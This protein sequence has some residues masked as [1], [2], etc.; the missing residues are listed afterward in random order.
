MFLVAFASTAYF[1]S[2]NEFC[3]F[4]WSDSQWELKGQPPSDIAPLLCREEERMTCTPVSKSSLT[5]PVQTPPGLTALPH[6]G[7][8]YAFGSCSH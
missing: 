3:P 2:L 4:N 1:H 6:F 7:L 8:A 5:G